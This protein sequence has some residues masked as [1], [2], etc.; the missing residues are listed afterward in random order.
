MTYKE[1][2]E[3]A[4]RFLFRRRYAYRATFNG[5]LAEEVLM[6]LA[7]FC[8]ACESTFDADP[9][10]HAALEGR[11]EVWLRLVS[12]LNLSEDDLWKLMD[13]RPDVA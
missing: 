3:Q 2:I 1:L 4:K 13:G 8:R 10:V 7:K 5:P 12:H 6:D 9:R 11:R